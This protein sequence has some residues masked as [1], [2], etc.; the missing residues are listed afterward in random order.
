MRIEGRGR[1]HEVVHHQQRI[2]PAAERFLRE[3]MRGESG[4]DAVPGRGDDLAEPLG[5][6]AV[7]FSKMAV[8]FIARAPDA[9]CISDRNL[10]AE[11]SV[12]K[13]RKSET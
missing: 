13:P 5:L 4:A 8:L 9:I 11:T 12:E 6:I 10:V 7:A 2:H 3:M 1:H